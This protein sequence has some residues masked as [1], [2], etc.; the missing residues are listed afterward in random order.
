VRD[1]VVAFSDPDAAT[2]SGAMD[3]RERLSM[4]LLPADGSA[5]RLIFEGCLPALSQEE[6]AAAQGENAALT[7]F[8]TGGVQQQL[9][10]DAEQFRSRVIAALVVA[11][12]EAPGPAAPETASLPETRL[13]QSL[14]ASGRL[15][16]GEDGLPRIVLLSNLARTDF[17]ETESRED[18]RRK[19]FADGM[20]SA[21]DLGRSELHVFLA[22]GQRSALAREYAQAFFLAQHANL[23]SWAGSS[24][25]AMPAA[26]VT[27]IRYT[28]EASYP[29]GP[30][31]IQIRL[32]VDRNDNLVN[33][34]LVLRGSPNRSTPLTG[35]QTCDGP[36]SCRISSDD[37]GFAQ[38]WTLSPGGEP[39]FDNDI[40][41]GG[42]REW[43]I[44]TR[45]ARLTGRVHDPAVQQ[46]GPTPGNNSIG[47][48]AR[49]ADEA[50]F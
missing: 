42:L 4:L 17:G 34:W 49:I 10:N 40:P 2:L 41:F 14:R 25:T 11:S 22:D 15:I 23:M 9:R 6:I 30:E 46:I 38:A 43:E 18:A 50:T 35:P 27:V 20:E 39:S 7:N 45:D 26:P 8:F 29:N 16:N 36:G 19:G 33:S 28:G 5:A 37:G 24:P 13:V 31:S 44:E 47:L 3:Y 32:A 12:R 21:L 48:T 1:V